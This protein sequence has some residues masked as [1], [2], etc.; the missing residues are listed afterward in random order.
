MGIGVIL[1]V[2]VKDT[3]NQWEIMVHPRHLKYYYL[4][5]IQK[6]HPARQRGMAAATKMPPAA[7]AAMIEPNDGD[8]FKLLSG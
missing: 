7:P 2:R 8:S 4:F 3:L 5:L 6:M 1:T